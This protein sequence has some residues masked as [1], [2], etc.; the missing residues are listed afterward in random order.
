MPSYR[1]KKQVQVYRRNCISDGRDQRILEMEAKMRKLTEFI[2]ESFI[3]SVGITRPKPGQERLAAIYIT[4]TLAASILAA[5]AM[6][7]L[8]L[9]R[10]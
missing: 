9:H 7:L 3:W 2:S 4:V 1:S 5:M 10:L 6:F 8:V